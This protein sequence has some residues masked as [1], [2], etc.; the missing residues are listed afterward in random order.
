[1]VVVLVVVEFCVEKGT[2]AV[3]DLW[4]NRRKKGTRFHGVVEHYHFERRWYLFKKMR[5]NDLRIKSAVVSLRLLLL[6]LLL[7]LPPLLCV[8]GECANVSMKKEIIRSCV[9][10]LFWSFG[11]VFGLFSFFLQKNEK[12][13][14][15][16]LHNCVD[17]GLCRRTFRERE[18]ERRIQFK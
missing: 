17:V 6:L 1:M 14:T 18:R 2:K 5:Q 13:G 15:S 16:L 12:K 8:S 7:C 9:S 11:L 4:C 3:R 10:P